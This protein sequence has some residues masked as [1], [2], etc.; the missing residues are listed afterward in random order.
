M[1]DIEKL[2]IPAKAEAMRVGNTAIMNHEE[3]VPFLN[4]ITPYLIEGET[5]SIKPLGSLAGSILVYAVKIIPVLKLKRI[6]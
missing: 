1:F 2:T 6:H 4:T 5:F 3:L